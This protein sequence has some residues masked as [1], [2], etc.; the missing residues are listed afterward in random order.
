V[1]SWIAPLISAVEVVSPII[2]FYQLYFYFFFLYFFFFFSPGIF[3]IYGSFSSASLTNS[4]FTNIT[5]LHSDTYG[6]VMYINTASYS[7]FTI[8]CSV[9]SQCKANQGGALHLHTNTPYINIRNTR[10]ENNDA[11][12]N[13]GGDDINV[14]ASPC[15]NFAEDGSLDSSVCSTSSDRVSCNGRKDLL[16]NNCPKEV[17]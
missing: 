7:L 6:G 10:F 13:M 11:S 4:N 3:M 17:V 12:A 16:K 8:N 15:F 9:F 5:S 2:N 1:I 14:Y